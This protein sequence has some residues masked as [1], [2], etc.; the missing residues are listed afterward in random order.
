MTLGQYLPRLKIY[1]QVLSQKKGDSGKIYSLHEPDTK[2]YSKGK[3]HKK[4]EFGSKASVLVDQNTG[5]IVGACNFTQT[6][7]DSRTVPDALEQYERLTGRQAAEVFVDRGYRGIKT[8]RETKIYIPEPQKNIT[9]SK[10]KKHSRR[11]AIEPII[12]HLKTDYRLGRNF[13][14]GIM[15]DNINIILSAA[16]MNFKRAMNLWR[17]EEIARWKLVIQY[18]VNVY[19]I[20]MLKNLF[21]T[22]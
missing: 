1:Q 4:F 20:F 17:T 12:G 9:K 8:Y 22:F 11:A 10:R 21:W 3:E 7:H 2:C 16:A 18:I 15:G 14:K 6:L 19:R 13:L 5:I